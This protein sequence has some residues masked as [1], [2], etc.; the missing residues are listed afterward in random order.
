MNVPRVFESVSCGVRISL[1]LFVQADMFGERSSKDLEVKINIIRVEYTNR[2]SLDL[3][4]K[5]KDSNRKDIK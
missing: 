5:F 2:V 1:S 3:I 4:N